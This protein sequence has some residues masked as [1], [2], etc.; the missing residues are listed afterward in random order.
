MFPINSDKLY[1]FVREGY[2]TDP[3]GLT[4]RAEGFVDY[5]RVISEMFEG[6]I[7]IDGYYKHDIGIGDT[8]HV[9]SRPDLALKCM[10]LMM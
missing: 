10:K 1:Y 8:F 3:K 2:T 7:L 9:T 6:V 5:V 4:W